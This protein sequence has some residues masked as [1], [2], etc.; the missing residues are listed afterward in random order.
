MKKI[1]LIAIA[2]LLFTTAAYAENRYSQAFTDEY[3]AQ[4]EATKSRGDCACMLNNLKVNVTEDEITKLYLDATNH[5]N[6]E[7]IE[8]FNSYILESK[9][10]CNVQ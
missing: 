2:P 10:A 5:Q 7:S 9:R 1:L 8:R 6:E 3:I 4:C